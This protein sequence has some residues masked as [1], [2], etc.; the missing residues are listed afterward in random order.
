MDNEKYPIKGFNT[1][2]IPEIVKYVQSYDLW[3]FDMPSTMEFHYG[4]EAYNYNGKNLFRNICNGDK[5]YN[6]F[7]L[8][9]RI[10]ELHH[11]FI[12]KM[13][14]SGE[15][16]IKYINNTSANYRKNYGFEITLILKDK[17]FC[18][19]RVYHGYAMNKSCGSFEFGDKINTY[20][21]IISF[22]RKA[23]DQW[24]YSIYRSDKSD[25]DC[26]K[27]ASMI[28]DG[29]DGLGGGGHL[30]ASGFQTKKCIFDKGYNIK[31]VIDPILSK[32]PKVHIY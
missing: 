26:S 24:T 15:T 27:L 32:K 1:V 5:S 16:I 8:D 18:K 3:K 25:L 10:K 20:D 22:I 14:T 2:E 21:F 9:D 28:A 31:I 4:M 29:T 11:I 6:I 7:K 30:K 17:L 12:R 13:I 23:N 19:E